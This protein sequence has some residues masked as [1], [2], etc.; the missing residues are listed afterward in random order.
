L[1]LLTGA[2]VRRRRLDA[3]GWNLRVIM[4]LRSAAT[5][6]ICVGTLLAAG[7]ALSA[8]DPRAA[9]SAQ[10]SGAAT[11]EAGNVYVAGGHVRPGGPITGDFV[12][13]GGR[14]TI[15]QPVR[16]DAMVAGGAVDVRAAVGD[17]LRAAG[18]DVTIAG[19]VGGELFAAG[20]S[21][22]LERAA[23]VARGA[24]LYGG[25]VRIDGAVAGDL[26]ARGQRIVINGEVEGNADLA[27]EQL[28]LGPAA[29]IRGRLRYASA[30][31]LVRSEGATV[32]GEVERLPADESHGRRGAPGRAEPRA[33]GEE[34]D[35]R[36][37]DARGRGS[38]W[39]GSVLSFLALLASGSLMLVVFPRFAAAAA[40]AVRRS[41][42]RALGLGLA[43]LVALPVLAVLLFITLLGI[44]LGVA[45][46]A[47]GPLVLLAGYLTA[48]HFVAQRAREALRPQDTNPSTATQ[49]GFFALAL[50]LVMLLGRLPWVGG[51][52]AAALA[53][54]GV[55][56]CV[57]E[58]LR[59]RQATVPPAGGV[60]AQSTG[61]VD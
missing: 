54:L 61:S 17:D 13:L 4:H 28:A 20:G 50:L 10:A 45:L 38:G 49:I 3:N 35:W 29:R 8:D 36:A 19:T 58:I 2:R 46:I 5:A 14:V 32:A 6:A 47:V 25:S 30:G 57:V 48:V 24:M 42:A 1:S 23:R 27:G 18:G 16:G 53:V 39:V 40:E 9:A 34:G 43:L 22:A 15:D 55:G 37:M 52:V 7:P 11:G 12:G 56:A 41:P 21:V 31:E 51:L 44:P 59:R 33:A 26:T 60:R